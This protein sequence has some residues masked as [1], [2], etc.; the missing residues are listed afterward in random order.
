MYRVTA[1]SCD[2]RWWLMMYHVLYDVPYYYR[3]MCHVPHGVA[4]DLLGEKFDSVDN[5]TTAKSDMA[6]LMTEKHTLLNAS[7]SAAVE[8]SCNNWYVS[9]RLTSATTDTNPTSYQVIR[10]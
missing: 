6:Q 3:M 10:I 9:S 4:Y 7:S 2:S 8:L 1:V 5:S